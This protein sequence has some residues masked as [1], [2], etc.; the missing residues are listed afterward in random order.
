MIAVRAPRVAGSLA[1]R[2]PGHSASV[3]RIAFV[4]RVPAALALIGGGRE[5]VPHRPSEE[6]G[7]L[8]DDGEPRAQRVQRHAAR[9]DAVDGDA[10]A[11]QLDLSE[12]Y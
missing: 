7:L 3:A 4:A 9:V 10:P 2:T 1:R 11:A 12:P 6:G 5:V 8:L